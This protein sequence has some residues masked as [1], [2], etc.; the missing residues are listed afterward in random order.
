MASL[1]IRNVPTDVMEKL[2]RI[3]GKERR[4]INAQVLMLLADAVNE[5]QQR[6]TVKEILE[7]AREIRSSAKRGR[8]IPGSLALIRK[9]REERIR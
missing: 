9:A 6:S 2:R 3:A 4:S 7:R 5:D 8:K 1:Q